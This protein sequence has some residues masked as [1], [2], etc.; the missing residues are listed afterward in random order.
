M[1]GRSETRTAVGPL[2]HYVKTP[3]RPWKYVNVFMRY[4]LCRYSPRDGLITIK[5]SLLSKSM[6]Q[7]PSWVADSRSANQKNPQLLRLW[8]PRIIT[9]FTRDCYRFVH[10]DIW[11]QS[12]P[13]QSY[14]C[15]I[16]FNN[17]IILSDPAPCSDS[18][19]ISERMNVLDIR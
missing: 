9:L 4:V 17:I 10:Q 5:L 16:N 6:E 11:I 18:K 19:F 2:E 15:K 3:L 7:N 8:T 14:F 13:S 12:T 1:A